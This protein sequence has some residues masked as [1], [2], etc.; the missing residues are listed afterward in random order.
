MCANVRGQIQRNP[1]SAKIVDSQLGNGDLKQDSDTSYQIFGIAKVIAI[2]SQGME[3]EPGDVIATGTPSG[4][5]YARTPPEYLMP[6]DVVE[7]E[8]GNVGKICNK[9][10]AR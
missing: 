9:I 1:R 4:V 8:V 5:G 10:V 2:L 7:C 6:G 3:L